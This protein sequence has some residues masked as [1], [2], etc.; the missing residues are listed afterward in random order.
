MKLVDLTR[1]I[2]EIK[3]VSTFLI[4]WSCEELLLLCVGWISHAASWEGKIQ[5]N[6]EPAF[7]NCADPDKNSPFPNEVINTE[8][9][10]PKKKI[11]LLKF[12][13]E[14]KIRP[15]TWLPPCCFRGLRMDPLSGEMGTENGRGARFRFE[16]LAMAVSL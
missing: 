4:L 3:K 9:L 5:S 14:A 1:T 8:K 16:D 10:E 15:R 13:L 2:K 7:S 12:N 6:L 11:P